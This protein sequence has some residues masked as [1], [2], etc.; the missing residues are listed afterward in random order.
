MVDIKEH[1]LSLCKDLD[2]LYW[3][4]AFMGPRMRG[5]KVR[6]T[7]HKDMLRKDGYLKQVIVMGERR[8]LL[9]DAL[10]LEHYKTVTG[11]DYVLQWTHKATSETIQAPAIDSNQLILDKLAEFLKSA[12]I[13]LS[14]TNPRHSLLVK[15][16]KH[17]EAQD[18]DRS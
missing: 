14:D 1:S 10:Y 11:I 7:P 16:K 5:S 3:E 12:N 4:F 17:I 15:F 13:A 2:V 8:T 6:T 9:F 18:N